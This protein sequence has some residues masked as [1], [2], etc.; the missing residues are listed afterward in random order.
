MQRRSA[1]LNAKEPQPD[2]DDKHGDNNHFGG[3]TRPM[4]GLHHTASITLRAEI[5]GMAPL[6]FLEVS[7]VYTR[8]VPV[9][10]M[11]ITKYAFFDLLVNQ[12]TRAGTNVFR[13]GFCGRRR[14][15]RSDIA[16]RLPVSD[17]VGL[18]ARV[19]AR[20]LERIKPAIEP[21]RQNQTVFGNLPQEMERAGK[22][23]RRTFEGSSDP[24]RGKNCSTFDRQVALLRTPLKLLGPRRDHVCRI[25]AKAVWIIPAGRSAGDDQ[26]SACCRA[27]RSGRP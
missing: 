9:A 25:V 18:R 27:G 21:A 23:K 26:G 16:A 17:K 1:G 22:G 7:N 19:T 15:C 6:H 5:D 8:T 3:S 24:R 13:A 2:G 11:A 10:V 4:E 14:L 12:L 20:T